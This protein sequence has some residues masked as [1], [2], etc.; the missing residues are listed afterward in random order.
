VVLGPGATL[1]QQPAL[2][3]EQDHRHRPMK[4]PLSMHFEL[5]A[6]ADHRVA[7]VNKYHFVVRSRSPRRRHARSMD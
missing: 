1:E 4:L 2:I 3:V 6:D 5:R 7:S